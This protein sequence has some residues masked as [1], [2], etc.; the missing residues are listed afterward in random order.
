MAKNRIAGGMR[1]PA[2]KKAYS[3]EAAAEA[4]VLDDPDALDDATLDALLKAAG[5]SPVCIAYPALAKV[6]AEGGQ[7]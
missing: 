7:G 3:K 4:L 2:N 1:A 6:G 5:P